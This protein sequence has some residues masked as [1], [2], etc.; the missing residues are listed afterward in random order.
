MDIEY[1]SDGDAI[2]ARQAASKEARLKRKRQAASDETASK[3]RKVHSNMAY[4][5]DDSPAVLLVRERGKETQKSIPAR[6]GNTPLKPWALLK[7]W[8]ERLENAP[9]FPV[10]GAKVKLAEVR[11]EPEDDENGEE[12]VIMDVEGEE[13]EDEVAEEGEAGDELS[14][15]ASLD[16]ETLKMVLRQKMA[17]AGLTGID[18]EMLMSSISRMLTQDGEAD[19]IAGELAEELLV[20]EGDDEDEEGGGANP[21]LTEWVSKQAQ[22]AKVGS[23][24]PL[25]PTESTSIAVPSEATPAHR[26]PPTPASTA[27][28]SSVDLSLSTIRVARPP[29][30]PAASPRGQKRKAD[31]AEEKRTPK[32]GTRAQSPKAAAPAVQSKKRKA[33]ADEAPALAPSKR[34]ARATRSFDAPTAASKSRSISSAAAPAKNTRKGRKG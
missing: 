28:S 13:W 29:Q 3:R 24:Q 23:E 2:R 6:T 26:R 22:S 19:D 7:D 20:Q 34:P 14:G 8:R 18:E 12:A 9:I 32:K 17:D 30:P 10:R 25:T 16:P 11:D 21:A 5:S 1:D 4:A 31:A 15:L 27:T 33:D